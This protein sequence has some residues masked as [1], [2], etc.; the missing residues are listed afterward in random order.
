MKLNKILS[1]KGIIQSFMTLSIIYIAFASMITI[2]NAQTGG[3]AQYWNGFQWVDIYPELDVGPGQTVRIRILDLPLGFNDADLIEFNIAE[4]G[5]GSGY[6]PPRFVGVT[7]YDTD[8]LVTDYIEWTC[9]DTLTY[10]HTY[11]IKYKTD[12]G[13]PEGAYVAEGIISDKG[14][15]GG[16]LHYIPE[17]A[18]GTAMSL[19]P[20]LS[21]LGLYTKFRKK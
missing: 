15:K 4:S 21:G 1:K 18:F 14:P 7:E 11:T 16:H 5:W 2:A 8:K 6:G 10:C 20:L 9:P 3:I 17:F 19:L 12:D 13:I